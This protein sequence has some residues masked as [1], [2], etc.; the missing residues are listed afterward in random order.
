[1]DMRLAG[2]NRRVAWLLFGLVLTGTAAPCLAVDSIVVFNELHYHPATTSAHEFVELYNENSVDVDVSGWLLEGVGDFRFPSNTV[3]AG[4]GFL[5][6]AKD[7]VAL[8]A[9]TGFA[10]ALGPYSGLLSN[11]GEEL[12]LRNHDGQVMDRL[13]YNDKWPW[14]EVPDGAGASLARLRTG[15]ARTLPG[16]WRA[17]TAAE[18]S[19]GVENFP[20]GYSDET[21]RFSE[22][23]AWTPT[24]FWVELHNAG[25]ELVGRFRDVTF[26]TSDGDSATLP[27]GVRAPGGFWTVTEADLGFDLSE[28]ERLFLL[29]DGKGIEF[30]AVTVGSGGRARDLRALSR[31]FHVPAA[32]TP[33]TTNSFAFETNI[34][35][36]EIMYHHRPVYGD[37]EA[38]REGLSQTLIAFDGTWRYNASGV[39]LGTN[40][41]ADSHPVDGADWFSGPALLG[42]EST[43]Q[44]IPEPIGT[45]LPSGHLTYYFETDFV[46]TGALDRTLLRLRHI[47]DDGAVF[48]VNGEE[49][50]RFNMPAGPVTYAT[51]ADPSVTDAAYSSVIDVPLDSVVAG[52]NRLSVEV[53]QWGAGSSDMLL[54]VELVA[55]TT[56]GGTPAVYRENDEE[57]IELYNKGTGRV[58]LTGW[59]FADG[60]RFTF[61]LDTSIEAGGYLVVAHDAA[62]LRARFPSAT[63]VGDFSGRLGDNGDRIE[64]VDAVG[65]PVDEVTYHDDRPWPSYAD[66]NGSSLELR[67]PRADNRCAEAWAASDNTGASEW[68]EYRFTETAVDPIYD[69]ADT[70]D[71]PE[72]RLFL[73]SEGEVLVDDV[74]VIEDPDGTARELIQN[75]GFDSDTSAWR[76]LGTH[77]GS[78]RIEEGGNG[79]L[80]IVSSGPPSYMHNLLET[81][82]K[83]G[84]SEVYVVPGRDYEICFRARWLHGSP[85]FR[86][87]LYY[88]KVARPFVLA[89]PER[90]GTPGAANSVAAA[91]IGPT[92]ADVQ[93]SPAVPSAGVPVVVRARVADPDGIQSVDL[94][95]AVSG[96]SPQSV[97]MTLGGDGLYAATILGQSHGSVIQ[98]YI[99]S[100][101]ALTASSTYP[102]AGAASRALVQ[103][104]PAG[105][106]P[107]QTLHVIMTAS[108]AADLHDRQK[109]MSNRRRGCTVIDNGEAIH[110]DCGIRL[111]G[112][113][114][115]R[116]SASG[117]GLN[118]KFPADR[119]FRGVHRSVT[120]RRRNIK[121]IIAKHL[122]TQAGGLGGVYN[123]I[124]YQAGYRSE[125]TGVTR[126]SMARHGNGFLANAFKDG[127]NV[128]LF[129]MEG[130]RV[131]KSTIDGTL[132]GLKWWDSSHVGW[133]NSF[134]LTD[135]GEDREQYR[136]NIRI[137]NNRA[138]DDYEPMAALCRALKLDSPQREAALNGLMD[139][140]QW[141]RHFAL[142][143]LCGIGDTYTA[144]NPHNINIAVR[145]T[146]GKT[147]ALP[148]DWDFLFHYSATTG[149]HDPH[150]R[151]K[152][153]SRLI[154]GVPVVT[155]L[156][157]GHLYDLCQ[158]VYDRAYMDTWIDHYSSLAAEN[159]SGYKS[160]IGSRR[161]HVLGLLPAVV[162]FEITTN[163]GSDFDVGTPSVS[164]AG[165]GWIDVRQIR[166]A[167]GAHAL[168]TDWL[169]GETWSLSVPLAPG[170][171]AIALEA[172][173]RGG[174]VVG[175]DSIAVTTTSGVSPASAADL[176][177]TEIH[178]QPVGGSDYEFLEFRNIGT[179]PVNLNG[180][181]LS[182]GV[183]GT[184]P[185]YI[186]P[187]GEYVVV[188]GNTAAFSDRYS[189][190]TSPW[191]FDGINVV[192]AWTSG[193]LN[194]DGERIA[195]RSAAGSNIA[196][197][198]YGVGGSWARRPAGEGATLAL[199]GA[200]S[201]PSVQ[202]VRDLC[203]NDADTWRASYRH[204]GSPG[205]GG[206][207]IR[208]RIVINELLAHSDAEPGLDWVEL[209]NP[210][211]GTVAFAHW[212]LSDDR[213]APLKSVLSGEL[214]PGAAMVLDESALGLNFSELGDEAVVTVADPHSN[215]LYEI[216][217]QDFG[218]S[219]RDVTFGRC[220]RTDGKVDF[221]PQSAVTRGGAN[222]YPLVGPIVVSEL[223]VAP[224]NGVEFVELVNTGSET[225]PLYDAAHPSNTWRLTSAVDFRFPEG[226][227]MRPGE[228]LVV[229]STNPAAF[230][231]LAGV[232]GTVTVLG[233][234]SGMLDNA[235]D[236]LKLRRPVDPEPDGTV[237]YVLADKVD[238]R[239]YAPWPRTTNGVPLEKAVLDAYGNEPAAWRAGLAGGTPGI[240]TARS[241]EGA[242]LRIEVEQGEVATRW[243][244]LPGVDYSVQFTSNLVSGAW[245]ELDIRQ[246]NGIAVEVND[247]GPG[248]TVPSRFYRIRRFE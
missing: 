17:S 175:T 92:Y 224:T 7:P 33:G 131:A 41:A 179:A 31:E 9:K 80:K 132:D 29:P 38:V 1:M 54:G 183:T 184:F 157:H 67:D 104:N 209:L 164:L 138:R 123:D 210:G 50:L 190:P 195:V 204:H 103:V 133:I 22:V 242:A 237:P 99:E 8:A 194:N 101:D 151:N 234:W 20:D 105:T 176:L 177:L 160:Y 62:G 56:D 216:D 143:S 69:P 65:N 200:H 141:T 59:Q 118:I 134:D 196:S 229:S 149:L 218:A 49:A 63:V 100:T 109:V 213:G 112:S 193:R 60:V 3:A 231:A 120:T 73:L 72:L 44:N 77:A 146:D 169:D 159:Y 40:W 172:L 238:Y 223:M 95:Y 199:R 18:G 90:H 14:P 156:F 221:P 222:A 165:R 214:A 48:Y 32:A 145:A 27:L 208:G 230:R 233:P 188:V 2:Y 170:E 102:A 79:T 88:N 167:G 116:T 35:I 36:N 122:V 181:V 52:A 58:D 55:V 25:P 107:V 89:Q 174:N 202:P 241:T 247:V 98:F 86:A 34:V 148:W 163:G 76:I 235:G 203:L 94:R 75:G 226:V 21:L 228:V 10:D 135:L 71:F 127:G 42:F 139:Y 96:G 191:F 137:S 207:D 23:P 198:T 4:R 206:D 84:G 227:R 192:G 85:Q 220:E 81:T 144:G 51:A 30:D 28:D 74:S 152:N 110:Y 47:I 201:V 91:N 121:E 239:P 70:K 57:W 248:S 26:A 245:Q 53:H 115:S 136:H 15:L 180:V 187:A 166:R 97:P 225:V 106:P 243:V 155:R 211:T 111:R 64:L 37:P 43:P 168:E 162:P 246:T 205:R 142:L 87:E 197:V 113:M 189:S 16:N 219:D 244:V 130:I 45:T 78:Q 186:V 236:A 150:N 13:T 46:V 12:T 185:E 129:K 178:Y 83:S 215:V 125:Q 240:V 171:N 147:V 217:F 6:V 119:L 61:P 66:G 126:L 93:H 173:D 212:Y 108:D 182:D 153:V 124:V 68:R 161:S 5:V 19:P 154:E 82:L 232:P 24:N 140:S 39:D 117:A 158:T 128:T 11:G 114:F